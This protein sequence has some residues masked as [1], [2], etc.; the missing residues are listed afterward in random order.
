MGTLLGGGFWLPSIGII[1]YSDLKK[2]KKEK[3][4]L[5]HTSESQF[6]FEG[7]QG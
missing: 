6:L 1:K 5:A 2:F 4:Y 3:I 7:N